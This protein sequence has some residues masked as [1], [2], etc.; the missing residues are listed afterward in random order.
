M[1]DMLTPNEIAE[2]LRIEPHVVQQWLTSGQL[3]GFDFGGEW[4]VSTDQLKAFLRETQE[5]TAIAA[6]KRTL[7]DPRSWALRL[8]TQ[9][10]LQ[11]DLL[12]GD[13]P[14]D[15]MGAFLQRAILDAVNIIDFNN[16]TPPD[17]TSK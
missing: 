12:A 9:P 14:P 11:A 16:P 10:E 17:E 3:A 15:S 13:Y 4:R 7:E 1:P 5:R 2:F 6:V 8:D